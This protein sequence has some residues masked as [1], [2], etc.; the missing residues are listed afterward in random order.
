M[1]QKRAELHKIQMAADTGRLDPVE[2]GQVYNLTAE[3]IHEIK[4]RNVELN[5]LN[6]QYEAALAADIFRQNTEEFK[7]LG[8]PNRNFPTRGG[9]FQNNG[10]AQR[11]MEDIQ[12]PL[13]EMVLMS[14]SY[15][16]RTSPKF[17][18]DLPDIDMKTLMATTTSYAP[19]NPRCRRAG[20]RRR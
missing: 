17:S 4:E 5:E 16:N 6:D 10:Q 12:R 8:E 2:G 20:S 13:S 9:Q 15:M 3:Q 19:P 14:R 18:V 7:K 1:A 11:A